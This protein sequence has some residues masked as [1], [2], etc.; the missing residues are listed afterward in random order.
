MTNRKELTVSQVK[1]RI[2]KNDTTAYAYPMG[3]VWLMEKAMGINVVPNFELPKRVDNQ[4]NIRTCTMEIYFDNLTDDI[5]QAVVNYA[6]TLDI[7]ADEGD[8]S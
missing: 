5:L 2:Q 1:C 6:K 3:A 7:V 8:K 4:G